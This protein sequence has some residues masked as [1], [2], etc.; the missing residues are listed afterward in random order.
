MTHGHKKALAQAL[1]LVPDMK[2]YAFAESAD[3]MTLYCME[4]NEHRVPTPQNKTYYVRLNEAANYPKAL[5]AIFQIALISL[6]DMM[7]RDAP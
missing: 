4:S 6:K 2:V 5:P 7:D 1:K 3:G